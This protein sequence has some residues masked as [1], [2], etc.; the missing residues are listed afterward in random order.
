MKWLKRMFGPGVPTRLRAVRGALVALL[1]AACVVRVWAVFAYN[2]MDAIF[3]DPGRHWRLGT[4]PLDTQ[5]FAAI[6]PVG[7]HVYLG[8]LAKLTSG[9]PILV[10][11]WTA[12]LS[13]S[14]PWL[15]YRFLRELLPD[16]DWALAG[17]VVFAA[18]PSWSSIYSYFM[19]ETLMLP[20]LGAALWVLW[21]A[22]RKRDTASFLLVVGVWILAGLTR[23]IC[24]PLAAVATTWI[25]LTQDSKL[26]KAAMAGVLLLAILGP[27][28]GRSWYLVR[29]VAPH[30][31]GA[32][33]QLYA[34]SGAASFSI[35]F[36]RQG[37]VRWHYIFQSPSIQSTPLEPLSDW[38]SSRLGHV[39]FD[40]DLDAGERDWKAANESLPPWTA[41]RY[42]WLTSDNLVP[43]FFG[44]SWPDSNRARTLGLV[45]YW[46]RWI[47]VPLALSCLV[48]TIRLRH[49]ARERMLPAM[50][51]AWILVQGF[52]PL[53]VN[54]GRYRK[55]FEGL[56]IAQCL[57]LASGS[58][59]RWP[60]QDDDADQAVQENVSHAANANA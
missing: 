53:A 46:S 48:A 33:N 13:L 45:N 25:W 29:Q 57:L 49:T 35:D 54:E 36:A 40:I 20:L 2:P 37:E 11:Y 27:L 38:Q 9:A 28:A 39:H 60:V 32:M 15:W 34:R 51:L 21:R 1:I 22:R 26:Q 56:L 10:A 14:G 19:Q 55:P 30:G 52:M 6:D 47:W 59:R 12:L 41:R 58:R 18:L 16:R 8:I 31:L 42:L 44:S 4:Q 43:L 5:P 23:G 17:W 3:S 50:L 24:I 7:Y